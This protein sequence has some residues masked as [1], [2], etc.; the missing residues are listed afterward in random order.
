MGA[1]PSTNPTRGKLSHNPS[2]SQAKDRKSLEELVHFL[3]PIYFINAPL[4]PEEKKALTASWRSIIFNNPREFERVKEVHLDAGICNSFPE[5]FAKRFFSRFVEV[6]PVSGPMF[7]KT[8]EKQGRLFMNM[9]TLIVNA[10]EEGNDNKMTGALSALVKSHCPMGIRAVECML[11][12][13]AFSFQSDFY[14][15]H[16]FCIWRSLVLGP[17]TC[18]G[19]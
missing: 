13:T 3:Q 6:H 16:R 12:S 2:I 5:Y 17:Q 7:S 19:S 10:E 4:N 8:S 18:I 15:L 11:L 14:F 1:A 9:I